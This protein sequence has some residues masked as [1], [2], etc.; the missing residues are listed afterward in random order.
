MTRD[1]VIGRNDVVNVSYRRHCVSHTGNLTHGPSA[2]WS[3]SFAFAFLFFF[4]YSF[5]RER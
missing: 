3:D 4:I 2:L 5:E 1:E